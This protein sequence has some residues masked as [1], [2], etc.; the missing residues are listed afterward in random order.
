MLPCVLRRRRVFPAIRIGTVFS[1]TLRRL[2]RQKHLARIVDRL[3]PGVHFFIQRAGQKAQRVAHGDDRAA[4]SEA[5]EIISTSEI[6]PS[7]HGKER[8]PRARLTVAGHQRDRGIQQ[9]IQETLLPRI[10]RPQLDALR[11]LET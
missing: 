5:I 6:K 9:R 7:R 10:G 2:K 4:H 8:F 11:N 3:Q 1:A